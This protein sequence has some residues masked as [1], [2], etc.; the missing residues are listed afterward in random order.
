MDF[1]NNLVTIGDINHFPLPDEV[2]VAAQVVFEIFDSDGFH[3][4]KVATVATLCKC[5]GF[6]SKCL[7]D[8]NP[9]LTRS[10]QFL[11]TA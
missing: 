5:S 11:V 10:G 4:L 3:L 8:Q 6:S 9:G 7:N 1:R 2:E